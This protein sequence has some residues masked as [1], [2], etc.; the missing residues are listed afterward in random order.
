MTFVS[1][2]EATSCLGIDAKTL[3]RWLADAQFPL[4]RSAH[5]A[6]KKGLSSEH[7]ERL[8][9]LHQRRLAPLSPESPAPSSGPSP[10]LSAWLLGC[11]N[12]LLPC[13]P[14][15]RPCSSK[16]LISPTS[17]HS[18]SQG[19]P[20]RRLRACRAR[21]SSRPPN[22]HALLPALVPLPRPSPQRLASRCM[23]SRAS[24]MASRGAMW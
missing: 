21:R 22:P 9:R 13:R 15:S 5:D 1:V 3:H 16:W 24:S 11:Q 14:R 10:E 18:T 4:H 6:R 2:A 20:S 8:A 7:I 19:L 12:S 23:S 17:S